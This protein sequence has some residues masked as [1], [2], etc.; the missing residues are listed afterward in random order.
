MQKAVTAI[1]AVHLL[2]QAY[3]DMDI[4]GILYYLTD[5]ITWIGT[6]A[7]EH[8]FDKPSIRELLK[9][10]FTNDPAPYKVDIEETHI[11]PLRDDIFNI[12][13]VA[14][15]SKPSV[16]HLRISTRN[17]YMCVNT[18]DGFK[19]ASW[20]ASVAFGAMADDEYFPVQFANDIMQKATCDS[21]TGLL[22]RISFEELVTQQLELHQT[23]FAYILIDLDNFKY[24][25]DHFGHKS[26]DEV[27]LFVS[28]L[29]RSIFSAPDTIGRLG[30]DEFVVFV[31][32]A[33]DENM[34]TDKVGRF[35]NA[36]SHTLYFTGQPYVPSAS[37]GIFI[38]SD[39][40]YINYEHCYKAADAAMYKAKNSGK[41][42]WSIEK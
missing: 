13:V 17:S 39:E 3:Q 34:V 12:F 21:L 29:L 6:G 16:D 33:N 11:I 31:P 22:N 4:D 7:H 30:G 40:R 18:E 19:I 32:S 38:C 2:L 28:E 8:R 42:T 37:V 5:N 35:I 41:S 20:H 9:E 25:N 10:D 36:M 15:Y 23:P 27:L 24:V 1:E 14:Y 26:G